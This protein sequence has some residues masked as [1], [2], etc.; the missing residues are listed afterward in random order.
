MSKV[1][2][3]QDKHG[4]VWTGR[5]VEKGPDLTDIL[6]GIVCPPYLLGA[7]ATSEPTTVVVNGES[8]TQGR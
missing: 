6:V 8:H 5:V 1:A 3:I 4:D 2:T 7:L